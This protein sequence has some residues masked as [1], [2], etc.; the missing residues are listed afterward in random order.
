MP[1]KIIV[2]ANTSSISNP[3]DIAKIPYILKRRSAAFLF[4][5]LSEILNKEFVWEVSVIH[6]APGIF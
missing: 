3:I 6:T 4:L 1:R 5:V 2:L